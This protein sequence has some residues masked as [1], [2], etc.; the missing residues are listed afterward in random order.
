MFDLTARNNAALRDE[1]GMRVWCELRLEAT[2]R[3][4]TARLVGLLR[5]RLLAWRPAP[6]GTRSSVSGLVD[7]PYRGLGER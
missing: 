1:V 5:M 2:E 3:W 6:L 7:W 4:N